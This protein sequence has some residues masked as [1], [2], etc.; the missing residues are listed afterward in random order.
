[1]KPKHPID[2]LFEKEL[3]EHKIA[4][5]E[6]AWERIAAAQPKA[7]AKKKH[8]F[9]LLRAATVT[10]LLGLSA[11][12]YFNRNA[13]D[14]MDVRP[15]QEE[16]QDE[17]PLVN[18]TKKELK[19]KPEKKGTATKNSTK[20]N[21]GLSKK[22]KA[23]SNKKAKRDPKSRIVPVLQPS[24]NDPILAL[25]DLAPVDYD[26]DLEETESIQDPDVLRIR[27]NLPEVQGNY[28]SEL[29]RKPLGERLWAYA[30]NQFERVVAGEK[31]EMPNAEDA[32]ISLPVPDFVNRRFLKEKK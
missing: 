5:S 16:V 3:K 25:N 18:S 19:T 27:V 14:L 20:E 30:N 29:N 7:G 8:G 12:L 9:Y 17:K 4:P 1:M 22:E 11:I 24:L 32:E 26:W 13:S 21:T 10:L 2:T 31:P 6:Q 23:P 15:G 28:K